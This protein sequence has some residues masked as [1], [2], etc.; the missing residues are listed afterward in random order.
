MSK[1]TVWCRHESGEG[2]TWIEDVEA[3]DVAAAKQMAVLK[4]AEDWGDDEEDEE[5]NPEPLSI[6]VIGIAQVVDGEIRIVEWTDI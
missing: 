1:Y 4:C 2:T 5:G 6:I 3:P